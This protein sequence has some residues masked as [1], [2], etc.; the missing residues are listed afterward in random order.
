MTGETMNQKRQEYFSEKTLQQF[1]HER[2][3]TEWMQAYRY[4]AL[5]EFEKQSWPTTKDEAWRRTH[6][7][8]I[9]FNEYELV[10]DIHPSRPLS[11]VDHSDKLSGLIRYSGAQVME[12][13]LSNA[14]HENGVIFTS[15]KDAV[16]RFPRLVQKYFV[17][18]KHNGQEGKF[19]ALN[20]SFWTH[21]IFLY[22]PSF[23][24]IEKPFRVIFE[25]TGHKMASFPNVLIVLKNG[26]RVNFRNEIVS[27]DDEEVLRNATVNLHV[28]DSAYLNYVEVQNLNEQSFNF[29][30][31]N[32]VI[33]RDSEIKTFIAA[34]GSKFTKHFL[35]SDLI[36]PGAN[37]KIQGLYFA[38]NRQHLDLQT[39]QN[40][41]AP[42]AS[43]DLLY[44][45]V[46][47][48]RAHAVYQGLI[49]VFPQAQLT[50]AYQT[51]RNLLLND[52]ARADSIPSLE[53]E[54]ND[55]RCSHGSTV[56]KVNAEEVFYLMSRG[57]SEPEARKMIVNGFFEDLLKD[58]PDDVQ[59]QLQTKI[60]KE[61]ESI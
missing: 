18:E 45:G 28:D 31:G 46:I 9:D 21:G 36:S 49:K 37:A 59:Q 60:E 54:A 25:E 19:Q 4:A 42:S 20:R 15:F 56:G 30:F 24:E 23:I 6:I 39:V 16:Q 58:A 50:D 7:S 52:N 29:S 53:I 11:L 38:E 14:L 17:H 51:N 3:E 13:R 61:L 34:Y 27:T 47:K 5:R 26:A 1:M 40:H 41:L 43:S 2:N 8:N 35:A 10:N 22:V 44:K 32:A 48:D 57:L 12:A 33:G 55:V